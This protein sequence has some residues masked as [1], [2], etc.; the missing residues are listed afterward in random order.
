MTGY[1]AHSFRDDLYIG[2]EDSSVNFF[3]NCCGYLKSEGIE[4]SVNRKRLD[5]YLVYITNGHGH[6]KFGED[7]TL[8]DAGNI[9]IYKAHED[10]NYFYAKDDNAEFYWIHFTGFGVEALL[11]SL[12]LNHK[13]NYKVGI[14]SDCINLFEEI[15]HEIQVKKP[16]YQELCIGY[17]TQI[18]S[19]FAR[20]NIFIQKGEGIFQNKDIEKAI[21]AMNV[22]FDQEHPIEYYAKK[23]NLSVYQFIRNFKNI[24]KTLPSKYIE[25][26][27][28]AKA[29]QL[30][31]ET[32]LTIGEISNFVGYND[33]FYFSKVFKRVTTMTPSD[34]RK[35]ILNKEYENS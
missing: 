34:F 4:T 35:S 26:I 2:R 28:I 9:I 18:L 12:D 22:E 3:I 8:L 30:L 31:L 13:H 7:Y 33:A 11:S 10:Q 25:R 27:R 29:R 21:K 23:A 14:D 15:I 32:N 6:Y 16:M 19:T 1:G 20:K 17:F 24:T 5:Y